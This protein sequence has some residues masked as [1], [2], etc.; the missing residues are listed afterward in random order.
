VCP[1]AVTPA[2]PALEVRGIGKRYP[3][4]DRDALHDVDLTLGGDQVMAV[5]GQSGCGKTTLLRIIAGLEIPDRGVVRI[6]G[7]KMVGEGDW[8]PPERRGIGLVFQE[9]ALFPHLR[10]DQNVAYGLYRLP[11][12]EQRARVAE[13]L[14]LVELTG[15]ERRYPHQLSGGQQQRVALARALAPHPALLLLDEPFSNLDTPLKATV[16]TQLAALLRRAGVPA[17]LVVHDVEDVMALADRVAVLK[18]G[19]IVR[20]GAPAELRDHPGDAYVARFFASSG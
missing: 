13:M 6:A 7:R 9:F 11:R 3:G 12:A 5:V 18:E 4:A 19:R 15:L 14:A 8:V 20:E 10:V 2:T 17:L 1:D 16:R